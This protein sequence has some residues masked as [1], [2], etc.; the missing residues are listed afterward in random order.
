M[1]QR[2]L[3]PIIISL[4]AVLALQPLAASAANVT[5]IRPVKAGPFT[6]I[7]GAGLSSLS[8]PGF[9]APAPALPALQAAP[10][11]GGFAAPSLLSVPAVALPGAAV[12]AMAQGQAVAEPG[13]PEAAASALSEVRETAQALAA[14]QESGKDADA[15]KVLDKAFDGAKAAPAG[16]GSEVEGAFSLSASESHLAKPAEAVLPVIDPQWMPA[17]RSQSRRL[18]YRVTAGEVKE[19]GED[20]KVDVAVE[21]LAVQAVSGVF[22]EGPAMGGLQDK[23]SEKSW[24]VPSGIKSAATLRKSGKEALVWLDEQGAVR[25]HRFDE[26]KTYRVEAGKVDLIAASADGETLHVVSGGLIKKWDLLEDAPRDHTLTVGGAPYLVQDAVSLS[27]FTQKGDDGVKVVTKA[28]RVYATAKRVIT[29]ARTDEIVDLHGNLVSGVE[30]AGNGLYLRRTSEGTIL[31]SAAVDGE[32]SLLEE[33]GTLPFDARAVSRSPIRDVY[34]A[35]SEE[36]LVEYEVSNNRYMTFKVPGLSEAL[37]SGPAGLDMRWDSMKITAGRKVFEVQVAQAREFLASRSAE[38]RLWAQ[39]NPMYVEG[40]YLHIGDFKFKIAAKTPQA[41]TWRTPPTGLQKAW[42]KVKS[43]FS[44]GMPEAVASLG[45]SEKDWMALN[46]PS[47]KRLIYDTLKGFTLHQHILYIGETGG[48][49]TW[50]ATMLAK[51]T[52]NELWMVSMNEYT[53]N[54]DLIARET[55]GEEGKNRTGLT[56]STV[57]RWM[58]EGGILVLDEM[59]KPLEGIAVLNNILQNGEYRMADGRTIKVDKTKSWVIGTMNPVKPPYKGEPPS[60]ELSSRFGMTLD[61]KYLPPDEEEALLGIFFDKVSKD[62]IHKLVSIAND[63]RR[64]YPEILPLPIAPRTLMHIVEHIQKFPN[65]NLADIFT[66]T[67]NPSSIVEDPAIA[68]AITRALQA[69]DLAGAGAKAVEPKA[70]K[71]ADDG[72][73]F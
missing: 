60:G 26:D 18:R 7:A 35:V 51:L 50:I 28:G 71:K 42:N 64:I 44:R 68:E 36:G 66:K 37:R 54:K 47:N 29:M 69:H 25:F 2:P 56:A 31:Y 12:P 41:M 73:P 58:Q 72:V 55:F 53:R 70:E 9:G 52:G 46:L 32:E 22:A 24:T 65:D 15:S 16:S 63:L 33:I 49:K 38:I 57:L 5:A 40:G 20:V 19:L 23:V 39:A 11:L 27:A 43:L 62:I 34:F 59:H 8:Q 1:T 61:V 67:Y 21:A 10:S 30:S 17:Q 14:G 13:A 6:G 4:A 45:I 48:G 3:S